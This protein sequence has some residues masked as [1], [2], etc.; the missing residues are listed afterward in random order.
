[1]EKGFTNRRIDRRPSL[2]NLRRLEPIR[3]KKFGE[4]RILGRWSYQMSFKMNS[5]RKVEMECPSDGFARK[6]KGKDLG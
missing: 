1:M 2:V 4:R 3:G 5:S 6:A